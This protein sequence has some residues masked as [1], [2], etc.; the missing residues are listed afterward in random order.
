[1]LNYDRLKI[2]GIVE[3]RIAEFNALIKVLALN[4]SNEKFTPHDLIEMF[5]P[6]GYVF[7]P[8]FFPKNS[9]ITEGELVD[10]ECEENS[11]YT[12]MG[13]F[14]K[15]IV[16][17]ESTCKNNYLKT[18]NVKHLPLQ[19]RYSD[20][21]SIN[22]DAIDCKTVFCVSD[23]KK[24]LG[25]L[26]LL[27]NGIIEP[28]VKKRVY[29]WDRD[30]CEIISNGFFDYVKFPDNGYHIY[31]CMDD[32]KLFEWFREKLRRIDPEYI[33]LLDEQTRW[34][35]D[36]PK[37]FDDSDKE[38]F[39]LDQ[40]RLSRIKNKFSGMELSLHEIHQLLDTSKSL[41]QVFNKA[42]KNHIESFQSEYEQDL[43]TIK[44]EYDVQ[45]SQ[46]ED[47][48]K[49]IKAEISDK[50]KHL[51]KL[52]QRWIDCQAEVDLIAKNK[53]RIL[54]DF[55]IVRDVL[56]SKSSAIEHVENTN[57]CSYLM[58]TVGIKDNYGE[59]E[60]KQGCLDRIK[61]FLA[62]YD[63]N[64]NLASKLLDVVLSYKGIFIENI[65]YGV[66]F[67]KALGN[68]KYIIQQVEP[69]WMRF[70]HFWEKGLGEIWSSSHENPNVTHLLLLEDVNLASPE[71]YA[72]PLIDVMGGLRDRLPYAK[73]EMPKNLKIL[74]T[75]ISFDDPPIGLPL[76]QS[77]FKGWG[78]LGFEKKASNNTFSFPLV[79]G[80]LTVQ[81]LEKLI[82]DEFE[83]QNIYSDVEREFEHLFYN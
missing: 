21:Q 63:L 48:L 2:T 41:R 68:T 37:F 67:A 77:T 24:I 36:F 54:S 62:H 58:E 79:N 30:N 29:V 38:S 10:C 71:C 69:D 47:K 32:P 33:K 3:K 56:N 74:A 75:K 72:R 7:G 65:A 44:K 18:F 73:T 66:A 49:E 70:E 35:K 26:R 52:E 34:R 42:I 55:S 15:Y 25:K 64:S 14:T 16:S 27:A 23:G 6:E 1:M 11:Q 9:M 28:V 83:R 43:A 22:T 5:P 60:D 82:P 8:S 46:F 50:T 19:G 45:K 53:E 57:L 12:G 78:A 59:I 4:G 13:N 80:Y 17:D 20:I 76:Y 81:T 51:K 61:Y 31:D 39:E 40:Y